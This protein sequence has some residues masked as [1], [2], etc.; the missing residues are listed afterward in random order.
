[1]IA[2]YGRFLGGEINLAQKKQES[3]KLE[4]INEMEKLKDEFIFIVSHEL[5]SPITA[6]RGYLEILTKEYSSSLNQ[7]TK[8]VL[9]K[10]F[11][12]SN[13]LSNL[14]TLLLEM[15]RLETG[16]IHFFVQKVSIK[17]SLGRVL[18][19]MEIDI[20]QKNIDM[21]VKIPPNLQAKIDQERLEEILSIIIENA[22]VYTPEFGRV[23][24]VAKKA[25]ENIE[26]T[27]AD[28]GVGI[29]EERKERLFEKFYT[30]KTGVGHS[31]I[32]S[33]NIGMYVVRELISRMG[34]EIKVESK[35]GQGTKFFMKIPATD[36]YPIKAI[37]FDAG[38]VLFN[39]ATSLFSEPINYITRISGA[40]KEKVNKVYREVIKEY[41]SHKVDKEGLW[42]E[43]T[44]KLGVK[45]PYSG[46]D[47]IAYGFKKFKADKEVLA[48]INK[49][50]LN[51]KVALVSN[52][53]AVEASTPQAQ[54]L[55]KEFDEVVLSFKIGERKP[56]PKIYTTVFDRLGVKSEES[57]FVDNTLEN[58]EE[59]KALGMK[60]ILFK[61]ANQLKEDLKKVGVIVKV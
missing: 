12:T 28:N 49:L 17:D 47:P 9:Q 10:A 45:L 7:K 60:G 61:N 46:Q 13:K 3:I 22:V 18:Y 23:D 8:A 20:E 59:A 27:V 54:S 2:A 41:E 58:V 57:V 51:Y 35:V 52:A 5:R 32:K 26:L 56:H 30:E 15:A 36:K 14:V 39:S 6:I 1:M 40:P 55:Y 44:E 24:V 42:T 43:I 33:I 21:R 37:I 25:K 16:N 4:E 34:G 29:S 48:L 53:N 11:S 38:G 50:K 19:N 31:T